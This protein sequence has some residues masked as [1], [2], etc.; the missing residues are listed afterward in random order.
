LGIEEPRDLHLSRDL[1][2]VHPRPSGKPLAETGKGV[3]ADEDRVDPE[4]GNSV[5][6]HREELLVLPWGSRF[7]LAGSPFLVADGVDPNVLAEDVDALSRR[8]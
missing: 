5:C 4:R 8:F 1:L 3:N 6:G 2:S 7:K